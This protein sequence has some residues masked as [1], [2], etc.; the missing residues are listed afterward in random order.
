MT[1]VIPGCAMLKTLNNRCFQWNWS[2]W[3]RSIRRFYGIDADFTVLKK[4]FQH[5]ASPED[6]K[7][8]E[9]T[10]EN[11]KEIVIN[12]SKK[13]YHLLKI[14]NIL[15]NIGINYSS[16]ESFDDKLDVIINFVKNLNNY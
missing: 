16:N 10:P 15:T 4:L 14:N 11:Q 5:R 13:E 6:E 1:P 2:F 9:F 3:G 12:F 7:L 8:F